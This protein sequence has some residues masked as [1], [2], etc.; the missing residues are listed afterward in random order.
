VAQGAARHAPTGMPGIAFTYEMDGR[1][2][3]SV[4]HTLSPIP[5]PDVPFPDNTSDLACPYCGPTLPDWQAQWVRK[6]YFSSVSWVDHLVGQLMGKLDDLGET[7]NTVV[8][9]LGD[10]GWQLGEHNVWGK[11]TNFELGTRI[12]FIIRAAG[13]TA[14][15][16]SSAL[17]EA[18]DLYPTVAALAGLPPPADVDGID[19]SPLW[20]APDTALKEVAFSEYPRC[21]PPDE[22][23][24][25]EPGANAPE[26]CISTV[27]ED[28]T[29]MGY[30]LRTDEW[31]ATFWMWWDGKRLVGDFSRDPVGIELYAHQGDK[32]SSDYNAWENENVAKD[33]PDVMATMMATAKK[34]WDKPKSM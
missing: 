28:F 32:G 10:H 31:R 30:S 33:H 8:A 18:V 25:P 7:D 27:R 14:P 22:A 11:H 5:G 1:E 17:V 13:Q 2:H 19:L 24:T 20:K 12:P 26:S 23:W 21:A 34:H 6:G 4:N 9:F 15:V 29:V 3:I 16:R